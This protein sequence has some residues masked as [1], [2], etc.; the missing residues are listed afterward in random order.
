MCVNGE[1]LSL[2]GQMG[3]AAGFRRGSAIAA[4]RGPTL[5]AS[6]WPGLRAEPPRAPRK[7]PEFPAAHPPDLIAECF[8]G[9]P[10]GGRPGL[11]RR[12]PATPLT[13]LGRRYPATPLSSVGRRDPKPSRRRGAGRTTALTGNNVETLHETEIKHLP[14]MRNFHRMQSFH[15]NGSPGAGGRAVNSRAPPS[16]SRFP[17]LTFYPAGNGRGRI[18]RHWPRPEPSA[19]AAAT[20][21]QWIT[22][23]SA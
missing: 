14:R 12:Y 19:P 9:D 17:Y 7:R 18:G 4:P 6:S 15:G 13:S 3:A 22:A 2:P 5:G 16:E 8:R 21:L 1:A 23:R 10:F 20:A 11:R